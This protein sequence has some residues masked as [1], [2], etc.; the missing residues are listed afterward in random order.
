MVTL[1]TFRRS[2]MSSIGLGRAP[3]DLATL[4]ELCVSLL[5]D[6][7]ARDRAA[8][9]QRLEKMRRA[10]DMWHLRGAL[11]DTISRVHGEAVARER[12]TTLDARLP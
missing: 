8:M 4:R 5:A 9:L 3:P 12:L 11:F 2:F 1:Q 10:D 6:V 7:P